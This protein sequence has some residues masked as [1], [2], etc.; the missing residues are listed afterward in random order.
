MY[1]I[2]LAYSLKERFVEYFYV[3][4][5]IHASQQHKEQQHILEF[6]KTNGISTQEK[7]Y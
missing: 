4:N 5:Y 6:L 1:F 2:F 3:Q 7:K